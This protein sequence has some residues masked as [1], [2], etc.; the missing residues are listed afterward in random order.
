M[1]AHI[2]IEI[3]QLDQESYH[4]FV[5]CFIQE[6]AYSLVIDTGASKTVFALNILKDRVENLKQNE[7]EMQSA[8]ISAQIG[9][10]FQ[11]TLRDFKLGTLE[12]PSFEVVLIDLTYVNEVYSKIMDKTISGLIGSDF[13]LKYKACIDYQKEELTLK[14]KK[15][16]SKGQV[17]DYHSVTGCVDSL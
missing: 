12:L 2:P 14:F 16:K 4:L 7:N 11:G 1:V 5:R 6:K 13:L 9:E 3:I 8:G 15:H 17:L 10:S